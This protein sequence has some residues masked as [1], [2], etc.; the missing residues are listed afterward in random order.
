MT[1]VELSGENWLNL[2][3]LKC[4]ALAFVA[5]WKPV[6]VEW[7]YK[8]H[9]RARLT[10]YFVCFWGPRYPFLLTTDGFFS[11]R[12]FYRFCQSWLDYQ[13]LSIGSNSL[14]KMLRQFEIFLS[15][16]IFNPGILQNPRDFLPSIFFRGMG[17]SDKKPT[18][19]TNFARI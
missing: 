6:S 12:Q 9:F 19:N 10:P 18:L 5:Y 8:G 14:V 2:N 17:Y 16:G 1:T 4:W 7:R 15:L 11:N 13:D 3:L